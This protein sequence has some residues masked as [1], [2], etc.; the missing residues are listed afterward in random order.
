VSRTCDILGF[1]FRVFCLS[2]QC[3]HSTRKKQEE[4]VHQPE[5]HQPEEH[6]P[7]HQPDELEEI[8]AL[9]EE[10]LVSWVWLSL[11]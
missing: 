7:E 3:L 10:P 4:Q 2:I 11:S 8:V 1:L 6:Q 9:E 5:E